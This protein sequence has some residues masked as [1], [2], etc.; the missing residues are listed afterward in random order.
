MARSARI[1]T[2]GTR[3]QPVDRSAWRETL[4]REDRARSV[5]LALDCSDSMGLPRRISAAKGAALSILER[6]TVTGDRVSVVGFRE[7]D[8][9]LVLPPT[10]S[11]SR[12]RRLLAAL[13]VGGATPMAAGLVEAN[14]VLAAERRRRPAAER[15]LILMSDGEANVPLQPGGNI[16]RELSRV[17]ARIRALAHRIAIIHTGDSHAGLLRRLAKEGGGEYH[18]VE[19]LAGTSVVD[20]IGR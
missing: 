3:R 5:I 19:V 6:S 16:S 8:A 15:I 11:P 10:S 7:H 14:R 4:R 17:L 18:H 20:I 13:D 1:P 9:T 2:E 12:A